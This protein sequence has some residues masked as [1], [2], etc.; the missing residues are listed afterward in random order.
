MVAAPLG[1]DLPDPKAAAGRAGFRAARG[2]LPIEESAALRMPGEPLP[3]S[4]PIAT[5]KVAVLVAD[6]VDAAALRPVVQALQDVGAQC[7]VVGPHLGAVATETGRQF[8][9][10]H[11]LATMPSVMFDAVL[12]AGGVRCAQA[13]AG[14]GAA[15]HFVLEA[16]KHGKAICVVGEGAALL[17]LLAIEAGADAAALAPHP[18]VVLGLAGA[19]AAPE[20]A[21]AFTLAIGRHR[22]WDRPLADAV[23]G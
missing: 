20:T 9:V 7:L 2:K 12:V 17:R 13:L 5:R 22:H 18:G 3:G 8:P 11:T 23:P 10:D 1:I 19:E 15:V 14:M 4:Q 21:K 6:G 16:Y